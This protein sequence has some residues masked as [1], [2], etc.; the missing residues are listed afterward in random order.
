MRFFFPMYKQLKLN[1]VEIHVEWEKKGKST[2]AG[3]GYVAA[4]V[5]TKLV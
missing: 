2:W 5:P 4:W 1:G 3:R